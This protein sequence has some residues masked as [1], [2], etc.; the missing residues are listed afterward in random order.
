[1][2]TVVKGR[3]MKTIEKPFKV[4]DLGVYMDSKEY[5]HDYGDFWFDTAK[6][7]SM[8]EAGQHNFPEIKFPRSFTD[9]DKL[10]CINQ[11]YSDGEEQSYISDYMDKF[12]KVLLK[13]LNESVEKVSFEY[14]TNFW[15]EIKLRVYFPIEF[16]V[17]EVKDENGEVISLEDWLGSD[18]VDWKDS[19]KRTKRYMENYQAYDGQ[20]FDEAY[21]ERMK[22]SIAEIKGE[23]LST[24]QKVK[25]MID[26]SIS[27]SHKVMNI[28]K[29]VKNGR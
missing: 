23:K 15:D 14:E 17:D 21:K 5:V 13:Y 4:I 12:H 24:Y 18:E 7:T 29:I 20:I 8:K 6:I 3:N 1:M 19:I 28:I 25:S 9:E 2:T 26:R 27:K 16:T 10:V 22:D 11:A